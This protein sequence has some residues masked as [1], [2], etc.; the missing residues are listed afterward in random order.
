MNYTMSWFSKS[1]VTGGTETL[2]DLF[3]EH[4]NTEHIDY[5]RATQALASR[6]NYTSLGFPEVEGTLMMEEYYKSLEQFEK[7]E[8]LIKNS[9]QM[10]FYKA[11][12][13]TTCIVQD[14]HKYAA[15]K[16]FKL[17]YY[18]IFAYNKVCK[19]F[20][21]Y[22]LK[23]MENS[24]KVVYVSD[25]AA[26]KYPNHPGTVI[27]HGVDCALFKP[28]S[29]EKKLEL[30][31]KLGIEPDKKVGLWVG[32]F[33]PQKGYHIMTNL[34]KKFKDIQWVFS[35]MDS[36]AN[37][38]PYAKNVMFTK[39]LNYVD[40]PRLYNIADFFV[41]PSLCE[42][43]GLASLEAAACGV[44]VIHSNTGWLWNRDFKGGVVVK[45]WETMAYADAVERVLKEKF[46]PRKEAEEFTITKWIHNWKKML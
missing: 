33:H 17:G 2:W 7:P 37:K 24:D 30:R 13:D 32:R 27:P 12:A 43:F 31:K 38:E 41:L 10:P 44:P 23:S 11:K 39:P 29:P 26:S 16:L 28:Y 14:L 46:E 34:A 5:D 36:M 3:K 25:F 35:F 20:N 1:G 22:Q 15:E 45:D 18:D 4:L 19:V 40:M 42:S 21:D 9:M 8:H 6:F